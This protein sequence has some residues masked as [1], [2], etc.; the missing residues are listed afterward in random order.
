MRNTPPL[1]IFDTLQQ[2]PRFFTLVGALRG[3]GL[4]ATLRG[5]GAFTLFAPVDSA[6][7]AL[8]P[9]LRDGLARD[10]KHMRSV[11]DYHLL[12]NALAASDLRHGLAKTVEGTALRIGATDDGF[13]VDHANVER[14]QIHCKNGVIHV[15]DAV[16]MPGY[17]PPVVAAALEESAWSGRRRTP[18]KRVLV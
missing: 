18:Q 8:D 5:D 17:R 12:R 3:A 15:I 11:L 7:A 9:E 6:F 14:T 13:T 16:I 4:E 1:S 10:F 2:Q